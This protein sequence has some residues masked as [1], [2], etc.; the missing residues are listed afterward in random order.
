MNLTKPVCN[1][2][3][4]LLVP[5]KRNATLVLTLRLD[6]KRKIAMN[7][8]DFYCW[9]DAQIIELLNCPVAILS[10]SPGLRTLHYPR[11]LINLKFPYLVAVWLALYLQMSFSIVSICNTGTIFLLRWLLSLTTM[12][13]CYLP[14]PMPLAWLLSFLLLATFPN[15]SSLYL[16]DL[17]LMI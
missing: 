13:C 7:C 11:L 5:H 14:Q 15:R 4:Q 2:K 9:W 1:W 16:N 10:L 6:T 3:A 8:L 17:K 12:K